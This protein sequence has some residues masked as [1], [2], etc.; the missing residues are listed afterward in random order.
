M[1]NTEVTEW[2]KSVLEHYGPGLDLALCF[3]KEFDRK[4]KNISEL[5]ENSDGDTLLNAN[6][7]LKRFR[8]DNTYYPSHLVRSTAKKV[9]AAT[10]AVDA[11][12]GRD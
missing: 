1:P 9:A 11:L 2:I 5:V 7:S 10:Q 4:H 8:R 12:V 6:T 3:A